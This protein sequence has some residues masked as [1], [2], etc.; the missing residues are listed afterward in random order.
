MTE[1]SNSNLEGPGYITLEPDRER[2]ALRMS[3]HF[4]TTHLQPV[5][6]HQLICRLFQVGLSLYGVEWASALF[7]ELG[8]TPLPE[9]YEERET[10]P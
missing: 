1:P 2:K 10:N 7:T 9:D 4:V 6:A 3:V 5:E 8:V